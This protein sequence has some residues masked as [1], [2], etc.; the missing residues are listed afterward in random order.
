MRAPRRRTAWRIRLAQDFARVGLSSAICDL[1]L[2]WLRQ[3]K[4]SCDEHP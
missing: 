1:L 3:V 4:T 2:N